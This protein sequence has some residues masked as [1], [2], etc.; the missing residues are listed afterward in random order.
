MTTEFEGTKVERDCDPAAALTAITA[1][2][3]AGVSGPVRTCSRAFP[4]RADQVGQ[5]RAFLSPMLTDCPVADDVLLICSELAANAV[6]HSAS[7]SPNGHFTVRAEIRDGEYAWIE[8]EDQ[9]GSWAARRHAGEHGRGLAIVNALAA[10][11]C[12]LGDDT[13]RV[14]CARLDWPGRS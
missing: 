5:A 1:F 13:G 14:A 3:G 2:P 6:Q 8:V 7:A 11:W 10:H 4:A 12:I 9:G